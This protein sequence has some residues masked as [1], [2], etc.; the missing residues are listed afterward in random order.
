MNR[1]KTFLLATLLVLS[2]S[3]MAFAQQGGQFRVLVFSKTAGF[4]HQSIPNGVMAL[5][6]MGEKHVFSVFTSEDATQFT[7]ENLAKFDVVVLMST[8]GTILN[9][10]QKAAF[11]KFVQSG[12]YCANTNFCN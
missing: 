4:R 10:S 8:T 12:C 3:L 2:S 11:Q 1:Y 5:K 6:K 7:D 9:D